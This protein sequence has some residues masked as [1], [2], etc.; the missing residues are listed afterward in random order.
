MFHAI[1]LSKS[2]PTPIYIQLASELAKLIQEGLL[3]EGMKLP[4][5]RLLSSQLSINRD[6]VVSAY[7]LL[8]QQGLVESH[9]GKG[10]YI[11]AHPQAAVST[12]NIILPESH[13]LCCSHL[14]LSPDF[15]P[16]TLCQELTTQIIATEGWEAF[17]DPLYRSKRLLRQNATAFLNTLGIKTHFAQ[18]QIITSMEH[19]L[20]SLFKLS[21]KLGICV[22]TPRDL[23]TSCYLRSIGAKIYEIPLTPYGMDLEILEKYLH[24]GTVSYIFVNPYLQNPTGLCYSKTYLQKLLDLAT[25]YDCLIVEDGT[26]CDLMTKHHYL[27]LINLCK[28]G[29]V[30]YLYHFSRM[31]LPYM[32]YSFAILPTQLLK[33]F[34]DE[35]ECH[36]NERF[37]QY[38]L[39]SEAFLT[40]RNHILDTCKERYHYL[41]KAL[42]P[43]TDVLSCSNQEGGLFIW[44][45]VPHKHYPS[46][47]LELAEKDMIIAPGELFATGSLEDCFRLSISQLSY[48]EINDLIHTISQVL[49]H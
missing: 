1:K 48:S 43:L 18:T 22:E 28:D 3:Y 46:L 39:A 32:K 14:S 41:L 24:T 10:T 49:L 13:H 21:P 17:C 25:Q 20:L 44:C 23:T 4:T 33:R 15:F 35:L 9:I 42:D 29:R 45:K 31:Y 47:C 11:S 2:D 37:L 8:E 5:I 16:S 26:Y 30:I 36:F 40:I 34:T 27:P 6:T 12:S 7:K 38:Y 19:F